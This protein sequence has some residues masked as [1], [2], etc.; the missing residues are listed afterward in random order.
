M[1]R[2]D[3]IITC[4]ISRLQ[5]ILRLSVIK[6]NTLWR[7]IFTISA[8]VVCVQSADAQSVLNFPRAVQ[9]GRL[10]TGV[11]VTNTA[12]YFAD[13]QFTYYGNDGNIIASGFVNPVTYRIP[14]KGQFAM[15]SNE[16]FGGASAQ[17]WIQATSVT[18]GLQGSYFSGDFNNTLE[19]SASS[20]SMTAQVVPLLPGDPSKKTDILITNPG[21]QRASVS[22]TFYS[23]LGA[24]VRTMTNELAAHMQWRVTPAG[25]WARVTS[26]GP[27][28]ATAV[29]ESED[30]AMLVN[31]QPIESATRR[32]IPH[33][34]SGSGVDGNV[35]LVNP[36]AFPTTASLKLFTETG[37]APLTASVMV[38]ANGAIIADAGLLTGRLIPP[39]VGGWL[40]IESTNVQLNAV[41]ILD[42]G[43]TLTSVPAQTAGFDQLVFARMPDSGSL[44]TGLVLV[45]AS[46][47]AIS[48]Q[49]TLGGADGAAVA[50]KTITLDPG[51]KISSL[52]SELLPEAATQSGSI[53]IRSSAPVYAVEMVGSPTGKSM[54]SVAPQRLA[55]SFV[56]PA[57][58]SRPAILQVQPGTDVRPGSQLRIAIKNFAGG[59]VSFVID[60]QIVPA[61]PV[62]LV[63]SEFIVDLPQTEAGYVS[64]R[65]R[66][67]GRDSEPV[68][69]RVT[70]EGSSL[71]QTLVG[72]AFYQKIET[73]ENGLDITRPVMAPIRQA[74]VEVVDRSLQAVV[75]VSET[76]GLG[77]FRLAVPPEPDLT[78]RVLSQLR[79]L[80]LQVADNTNSDTL[81]LISRDVDMREQPSSL[82]LVDT[83]RLSGAFN[84]LEMIQRG[85][86]LMR[87]ADPQ[88]APPAVTVFWS[89]RNTSRFGDIKEGQVGTT[90][91]NLST[92]TAFVLGDRAV[93]SD[94][95]DDSVIL[96]EYAHMLAVR[97]SRDD[98][99]GG[100]HGVGDILDARV[101][102]SEGF[103]NFFSSAARNDAIYRDSNGANGINVLRYDLE[104]NSPPGDQAGYW[105]E[106][107]V[108]S[109]LWDLIDERQ[110]QGDSVQFPFSSVWAAVTDLRNNRFV[111][112]PYFLEHFIARNPASAETVRNMVL[113]RSIDFQ[114][115]VRPSVTNPFPRAITP[116]NSVTGEV[117]SLTPKRSNLMQSAHFF[118][119]TISGGD[120]AVRLD[121]LGVGAGNNPSANDLDLILLDANGR[122]IERSD[123]G[124]NGQSELIST[125]LPAGSYVIEVRSFYSRASTNTQVFNS[126]RYRLNLLVQ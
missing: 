22:V 32:V 37:G 79:G 122:V 99:P 124:L 60:K 100:A 72:R 33:F 20:S 31:G 54:T 48:V 115:N 26:S 85:N 34:N 113:L 61:R 69:L 53:V 90:Y 10:M 84:I 45:N 80:D 43:S 58:T 78:I 7:A 92:N 71:T 46:A 77:Q 74:R 67:G 4:L 17:G 108:Q 75:S 106:A 41:A 70:P 87:A 16:I 98:S 51:T 123:R 95:F 21:S 126:G 105:S 5:A 110:D 114:P 119:F 88:L 104:D 29:V 117:D 121:I 64:M 19:G 73:T 2:T 118:A 107:S 14:P 39:T 103:A 6:N 1:R 68:Q 49:L 56:P 23:A 76:D 42:S 116:G 86:D 93:D 35:V 62:S 28:F 52:V 63:G 101:A 25:A 55:G 109:L 12:S 47:A 24:E 125:R 91:F 3:S 112:L 13:V 89:I 36:S 102:W 27:V 15:L 30:A 57:M 44:Y 97:F 82:L 8:L 65:L 96:H 40:S 111:Y 38:P 66:T 9:D 11:A 94:E 59:D 50:S 81:Y 83:T 18:S 120:V